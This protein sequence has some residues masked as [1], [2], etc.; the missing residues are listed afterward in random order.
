MSSPEGSTV[1]FRR[2]PATLRKR[3]L[4]AF[5]RRLELQVARGKPFDCLLTG[6]AE[7]RRLNRQFRGLDYA[8]DVLSF[9]SAIPSGR[10][11]D[12]AISVARARAQARRFGHTVER[13]IHILMLHGLLHLLGMD[14][15][16]DGGRMARAEKR[17]RARLGLP[18]GLIERQAPR[19]EPV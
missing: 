11:G 18:G 15:E 8:T 7:L 19:R 10:L 3:S 12:L 5:A 9:P 16:T 1:T 6:D 13:E 2:P 14:H 17:W 4:A